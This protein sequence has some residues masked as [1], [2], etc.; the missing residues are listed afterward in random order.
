MAMERLDQR[1]RLAIVD[2]S[3]KLAGLGKH[4]FLAFS[5][6]AL[7]RPARIGLATCKLAWR[8]MGLAGPILAIVLFST[9]AAPADD[10]P[11]LR[12]IHT[13]AF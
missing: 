9:M 11:A 7:D 12:G 1:G 2:A 4:R 5:T 8:Y 13:I 10:V 6:L 3:V